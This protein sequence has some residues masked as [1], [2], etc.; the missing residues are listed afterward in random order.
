MNAAP[1][2]QRE[3]RKREQAKRKHRLET[4]PEFRRRYLNCRD[5]HRARLVPRVKALLR[6]AAI[7]CA[8]LHRSVTVTAEDIL[9]LWKLQ[10]G[11]CAYSGLPM[12]LRVGC[13]N[14]VSLERISSAGGYTHDNVVLVCAA[15]N[16]MKQGLTLPDFV[17]LC[18]AVVDYNPEPPPQ[19]LE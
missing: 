11:R 12:T 4:D 2:K 15:V 8:K 3:Y 16:F 6:D 13:L 14:T 7:R 10:R 18:R 5:K 19:V 1:E 17:R 9:R